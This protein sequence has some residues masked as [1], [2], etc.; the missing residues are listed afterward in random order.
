ML[1]AQ[2]YIQKH[3]KTFWNRKHLGGVVTQIWGG[4]FTPPLG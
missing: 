3:F 4:V 2:I 1:E